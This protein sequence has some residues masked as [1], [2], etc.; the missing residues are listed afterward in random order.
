MELMK[1]YRCII[2][3]KKRTHQLDVAAEFDRL[4][5]SD[6]Q[7]YWRMWKRYNR[8]QINSEILQ[9]DAFTDFFKNTDAISPGAPFNHCFMENINKFILLHDNGSSIPVCNILDEILNAP[10][11][12]EETRQSLKRLK[13]NKA[14][15]VDGIP[16]EFYKNT[17]D[18]LLR[19]LNALFN[20]VL[21]SGFYPEKWCEGV[22]HPLH[23]Q[24][25]INTP[26][27]YRKITVTPA[28]GK[29][30]DGILN[31]RLRFAKQCLNIDDPYQYG[32]KENAGAIDSVFILN[33]LIDKAKAYGRPLYVCFIDFKSAFDLINRS[34]L[35]FKLLNCGIDGKFLTVIKSMF[36]KATSRVKWNG[37]L[38]EM[39]Q[40]VSGVRQKA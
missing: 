5:S 7:E 18:L 12:L 38:G 31:R 2:Q 4:V 24:G 22:I 35:L 15:G 25:A 1:E 27:N 10:I 40:N 11:S 34:A 28:L 33:G 39:F 17:N 29:A 16:S 20:Y 19:P 8:N 30:F 3:T 6:T 26:E 14:A 21:D 37:R 13:N 9:V 36:K 32:F 23:K